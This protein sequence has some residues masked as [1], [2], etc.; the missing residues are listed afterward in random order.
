MTSYQSDLFEEHEAR[1]VFDQLLAQARTYS[2]GR[3]FRELLDFSAR[4]P[5]FAPFNAMLLHIQRPGLTFATSGHE[6]LMKFNRYPKSDARPLLMLWPF[7]PVVFVYDVLDTAGAD[8]PEGIYNFYARGEIGPGRIA[9]M[10]KSLASKGVRI[11]PIDAGDGVAGSI[12]K[13]ADR[14]KKA[15]FCYALRLNSRHPAATQFVTLAHELG[16][17]FL[18]HLGEDKARKIPDRSHL[19]HESREIEAELVAYLVARRTGIESASQSY[20][21][22][23]IGDLDRVPSFE[24]FQILRAAGQAETALGISQKLSLGTKQVKS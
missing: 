7:A 17:L 19:L 11:E 22:G 1:T 15:A 24:L 14:S 6:W 18:G 5:Q 3:S 10:I 9:R 21:S 20:L 16:H 8:L 13:Q 4:M 12:Q 2:E 23:Y